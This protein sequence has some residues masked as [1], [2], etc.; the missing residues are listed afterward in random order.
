MQCNIK[1]LIGYVLGA[2]D[3]EIGK[4]TEFYFDDNDGTVRYL[5]VKTGSWL[6]GR[7]VLV[8]PQAVQSIDYEKKEFI[9]NLTKEQVKDS[10][11]I[12]TDKPVS[13]Q[14]EIDLYGHY[15]WQR[16][17]GNGFYAGSVWS[18]LPAE[19][20]LNTATTINEDGTEKEM[21]YDLHLRSTS[22]LHGYHIEAIDG[23]FGYISDF[24]VDCETWKILYLVVDT[25]HLFG[26]KKV[27]IT[28]DHI[29]EINWEHSKVVLNIPIDIVKRSPLFDEAEY[30]NP[31]SETPSVITY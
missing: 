26:G 23:E 1:S 5:I 30:H 16:Y 8:S 4:V 27:M 10:P 28:V 21:D 25:H 31:K 9:V 20:E 19:I 12:D 2:K 7:N 22:T 17:G 24:V 15:A 6:F 29:K 11:D 14:Q 18:V 13:R 3:G